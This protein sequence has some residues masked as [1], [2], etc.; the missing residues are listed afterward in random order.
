MTTTYKV[1]LH[2]HK[3][4]ATRGTLSDQ[5]RLGHERR[6]HRAS[7]CSGPPATGVEAASLRRPHCHLPKKTLL[8][9]KMVYWGSK[10]NLA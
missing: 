8:V 6:V 7:L 1:L 5:C 2:A 4:L 3:L 10:E 9:G